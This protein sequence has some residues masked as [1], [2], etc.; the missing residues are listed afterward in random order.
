MK[1]DSTLTLLVKKALNQNLVPML[2]GEP[3]I[4]KSSWLVEIAK[5][6]NTE[7]F[8]LAC[9]QL[10]DKADLTGARLVPVIAKDGTVQT[11]EQKFY[12]HA[13]IASAIR[14]AEEHPDETPILFMDELNRTTPDITS[15]A[16]S[17]PTLREIGSSKLPDNLRVVIAGNDKGNVTALDEAS[18]SRF[19]LYRVEPDTDTF[20]NLDPNLHPL[21]KK[22]LTNHPETIFGKAI[23]Q[24]LAT[25]GDD[26][27][28]PDNLFIED[29][30]D[31]GDAMQQI[32]APRT[33][34]G[35]SNW[36]NSFTKLEIESLFSQTNMVDGVEIS[37]LQEAIEGHVGRTQFASYLMAEI[38]NDIVNTSSPSG[39]ITINKPKR[40][41]DL[42]SCPDMTS[43]ND[44][45]HDLTDAERSQMLVYAIYEPA[46]NAA[47]INVLA[48]Q[49]TKLSP[50][51]MKTLMQLTTSDKL[52]TE[53]VQS[54]LNTNTPISNSLS[55]IL[56]A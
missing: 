46:D 26:D 19:I 32:T 48:T 53:N 4:G 10:A 16:L 30:L 28:N 39:G 45:V 52:D 44:F 50:N 21:I 9:N 23:P 49:I 7:A 3:G 56:E 35:L 11:Y 8:V 54:L 24:S 37:V 34:S 25:S 2:L 14:Y 51:D 55:I 20:M 18:I 43:L 33:I 13:T 47:Y 5:E 36:L 42:K 12:P 31:E 41:H 15:A 22:V 40:Y 17:I 27:E 6:M 1:F 29:I 38:A